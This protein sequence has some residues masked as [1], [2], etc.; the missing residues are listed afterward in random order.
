MCNGGRSGS[1]VSS[2]WAAYSC[3][4]V[5][6]SSLFLRIHFRAFKSCMWLAYIGAD[7]V[8]I[9][10]LAT[11]FNNRHNKLPTARGG[12]GGGVSGNDRPELEVLW[13][14]V[15]LLHLGG[16]HTFTA[17]S[18]EDNELWG[19]ELVSVVSQVTVALYVFCTSWSV[20]GGDKKLL[21]AS[22]LLFVIGILKSVQKTWALK[23][24]GWKLQHLG[25]LVS[26]V[27]STSSTRKN[28]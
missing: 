18:F 27:P 20:S 23:G 8:A 28:N 10:G 19:R 25:D 4:F 17:Y 1:C 16:L 6:F 3:R 22:V 11:L 7:A 2:S 26:R 9:Y 24:Q 5:L 14:P 21:Q 15:L 13:A 12:G